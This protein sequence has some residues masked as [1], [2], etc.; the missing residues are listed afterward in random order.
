MANQY[1]GPLTSS[2]CALGPR[3]ILLTGAFVQWLRQHFVAA[4]NLEDPDLA[5]PGTEFVW[6][7]DPLTRRISIESYTR[8]DADL[9]ENRPALIVKR[10]GWQ[11]QRLA[12]DNRYHGF[13]N[14]AGSRDYSCS[15]LGSHTVFVISGEGA[16]CEKL[17][18]EV[19]R[20]LNQF[21]PLMRKELDLLRLEVTEVGELSLLEE[22]SENFVVPIVIAYGFTESW[23]LRPSAAPL[24]K[25]EIVWDL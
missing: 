14:P 11:H 3:P 5:K 1:A 21:A 22:A 20:E 6:T 2:F 17:A 10:N 24:R 12:I 19:Y 13:V 15:W 23:T 7:Q 9:V 4:S 16:E 18:A 25:A 8:W